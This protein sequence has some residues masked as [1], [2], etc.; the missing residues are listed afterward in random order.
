MRVLYVSLS[1]VLADQLSKLFIKG[2]SIPFLHLKFSGMLYGESRHV[3]GK[4][5][6]IT[7]VENPAMAFSIDPGSGSVI[8]LSLFRIAASIGILYYLYI[9]RHESL[10]MRASLALLLGGAVGNL[11]D[12]LFYGIAYGYAPVFYGKVVDFFEF[13]FFRISLFGQ[14]YESFPIF[15]IADAAVTVGVCLLILSYTLQQKKTAGQEEEPTV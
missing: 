8:W 13:S 9:S 14:S 5:F 10:R 15:N 6:R 11:I 7:F 2:F 12:R 4:F 1:V 3:I